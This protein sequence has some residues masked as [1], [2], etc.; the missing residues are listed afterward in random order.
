M[1]VM[2]KIKAQPWNQYIFHMLENMIFKM[3]EIGN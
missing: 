1:K 3:L 2:V